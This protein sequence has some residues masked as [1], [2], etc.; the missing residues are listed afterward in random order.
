MPL[1]EVDGLALHVERA[2]AGPPVVLLHGF[3][4]TGATWRPLV[5]ALGGGFTTLAVDLVGHGASAA[6]AGVE[7]YRMR[8]VVDDLAALLHA[9]GFERAAWVGYSLGGRVALQ[10]AVH[11]PELVSALVLE[12]ASAGLATAPERAARVAA[13]EALAGRIERDGVAAFVD[14]WQALPLWDSQQETLTAAQRATLRAQRLA[15]RA[16]GLANSLRGTGTGAQEWVGERLGAIAV[17]VLLTAGSLDAKFA[18]TAREMAERL[19]DATM[20]LIE[21]AGHAAHLERPEQ[22][23]TVVRAFLIGACA[24]R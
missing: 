18:G 10:V 23:N 16:S 11:R 14:D 21:G 2:G 22:F 1:I 8:R 12:G 15:Q 20:R 17:P 3:T 24:R 6:P 9:L 7:R 4:G 5:E 19:P 13:D